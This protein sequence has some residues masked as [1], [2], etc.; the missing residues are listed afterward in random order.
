MNEI[1]TK[2]N[3]VL[4]NGMS[5][6]FIE[7]YSHTGCDMY[8]S[9]NYVTKYAHDKI[10]LSEVTNGFSQAVENAI[11]FIKNREPL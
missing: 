3:F 5:L 8:K 9:Y 10:V 7:Y 11:E 1:D 6:P 4:S 2:V